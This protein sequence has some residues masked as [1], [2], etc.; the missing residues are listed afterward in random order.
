MRTC[1]PGMH[2]YKA[3][4]KANNLSIN[5]MCTHAEQRV[6]SF[7]QYFRSAAPGLNSLDALILSS[8]LSL[9]G[10]SITLLT[11]T[12]RRIC[13]SFMLWGA[14]HWFRG[15]KLLRPRRTETKTWD[16]IYKQELSKCGL[17][18]EKHKRLKLMTFADCSNQTHISVAQFR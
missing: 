18:S 10:W 17:G 4:S 14:L 8:I 2:I 7:H 11:A 13:S 3:D 12:R 1:H 9:Q 5:V 16:G 15:I 6:D